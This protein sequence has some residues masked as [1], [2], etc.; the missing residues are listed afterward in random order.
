MRFH[1]T[2]RSQDV[3]L[4]ENRCEAWATGQAR[5]Y[6]FA[7]GDRV[8]PHLGDRG[9]EVRVD[10]VD[11]KHWP[12][13]CIEFGLTTYGLSQED[14]SEVV[15]RRQVPQSWTSDGDVVCVSVSDQGLMS[16]SV[17]GTRCGSLQ[18]NI[19]PPVDIWPIVEFHA[20]RIRAIFPSAIS[21]E[22]RCCSRF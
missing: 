19:S 9:F 12:K 22:S 3:E 18:T 5:A 21:S 7:L 16:A 11:G 2:L 14:L 10:S 6:N 15:K 13:H 20:P 17:N 1:H 4:S 8:M